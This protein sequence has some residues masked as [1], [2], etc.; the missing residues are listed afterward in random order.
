[1]PN[2]YLVLTHYPVINK[3]GDTIASA[4]TNLDLHDIAR[5]AKTYGVNAFYAVTP[6]LDQKKLIKKIVAHWATGIGA[7]YNPKRCEALSLI[8]VKD[9]LDEVKDDIANDGFG[10]P[11]TVVTSAKKSPRSI[12]YD[13]FRK[14]LNGY[15]PYLLIFGTAWGLSEEIVN[16]ADYLLEPIEGGTDYNHLSVRSAVAII[17]DRLIVKGR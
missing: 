16:K 3:N 7:Q 14:M 9:S 13:T 12:H 4:V 8:K 11:K 17:L 5:A 15:S 10:Y 2:L 6:L 1:M